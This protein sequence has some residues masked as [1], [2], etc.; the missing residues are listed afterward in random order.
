MLPVRKHLVLRRQECAAAFHQID[1]GKPVLARDLLRPQM[2]L[3]RDRIVRA[4]LDRRVVGDDDALPPAHPADAGDDAAA[5]DAAAVHAMSGE[6]RELEEGA[7]GIEQ[8][9]DA[10]PCRQL[11]RGPVAAERG[12]RPPL[13]RA[14]D[15]GLELDGELA[16]RRFVVAEFLRARIDTGGNAGHGLVTMAGLSDNHTITPRRMTSSCPL[17][18]HWTAISASAKASRRSGR[19][20]GAL[21]RTASPRAPP[22]STA[23][24]NSRAICGPPWV[25]WASSA[26]P[27]RSAGAAPG[28]A[29]W[30]MPS[31]WRRS[32]APRAPSA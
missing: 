5:G 15:L 11:A 23:A 19:R 24:T 30:R 1:T 12:P 6:L 26:S 25:G 4:T 8:H 3:D 16:H 31:P 29:T 32:P 17:T 9:L 20:C 28:S 21:P 22:T 27:C 18:R 10:L 2:L 7:A 14:R 13:G